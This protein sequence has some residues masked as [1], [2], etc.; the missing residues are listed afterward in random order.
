MRGRKP[1]PTFV[2]G[3][4]AQN[5]ISEVGKTLSE[6]GYANFGGGDLIDFIVDQAPKNL[7]NRFVTENTPLEYKLKVLLQNESIK[8]DIDKLAKKHNFGLT[9]T[10]NDE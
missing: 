5:L 3:E 10:A 2:L 1:K 6:R 9:A 7:I 8:K 4:K